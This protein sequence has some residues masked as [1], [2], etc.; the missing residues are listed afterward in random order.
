[1][2]YNR[3]FKIDYFYKFC[4]TLNS[5]KVYFYKKLNKYINNNMNN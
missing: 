5:F 2:L 1:M 3:F 4:K